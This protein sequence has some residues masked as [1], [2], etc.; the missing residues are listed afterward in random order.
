[1]RRALSNV[2]SV[3]LDGTV[4]KPP[5]TGVQNSV[6]HEIVAE[7]KALKWKITAVLALTDSPLRD[8]TS[9]YRCLYFETRFATGGVW[10]RI[11]WQ[12]TMLPKLLNCIQAIESGTS[13]VHILDGRIPHCM[14]LEI[15]TNKGIGTAIIGDHTS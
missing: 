7:I 3:A 8:L 11:L 14:L 15:F 9:D 10:R 13:R 5:Y 6:Q 2:Y 1:M 4:V 12:Q